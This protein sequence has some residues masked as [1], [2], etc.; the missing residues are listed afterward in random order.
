MKRTVNKLL[1]G[2]LVDSIQEGNA[3]IVGILS[4]VKNETSQGVLGDFWDLGCNVG[5]DHIDACKIHKTKGLPTS[6]QH[7]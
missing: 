4:K 3:D 2:K 6:M 7:K 5:T 1:P